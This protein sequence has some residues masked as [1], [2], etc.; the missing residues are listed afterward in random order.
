MRVRRPGPGPAGR[1]P[2][3]RRPRRAV[4]AVRLRGHPHQLTAGHGGAARTLAA[5]PAWRPSLLARA[6]RRRR[7]PAEGGRRRA[8]AGA[9]A[10][11]ST[12]SPT[13][14]TTLGRR[15]GPDGTLLFDERA[16]G[17][18]AVLPDGPY[19]RSTPTSATCWPTGDRA[20]GPRPRPGLRRQ[21]PVLT[22]QGVTD[23]SSA[24]IAVIAWT[25][26]TTGAR[27]AGG[28]PA[29]RRHPGQQGSGRHGGCRLRFTP[30]GALLIGTGD[31]AV[32]SNPQD[33]PRWPARCCAPTQPPVRWRCGSGAPKR[34]GPGR[35]PGTRTG[36][37]RRARPRSATTSCPTCSRA[38]ANYGWNPVGFGDVYDES[39]PMT[40]PGHPGRCPGRAWSLRLAD[41]GHQWGRPSSTPRQWGGL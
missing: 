8:P 5:G 28:R 13:G 21:P 27:R 15:P 30:D 39:V 34:P 11:R 31:N 7:R 38:G 20:D 14:W 36:V 26:A 22:C 2:R 29:D 24:S 3:R 37:L 33:R 35:A 40:D 23:G 1:R 41:A 19:R 9:P 18:T 25:V 10:L 12:S 4:G 6:A 17:F 16:G 32:G